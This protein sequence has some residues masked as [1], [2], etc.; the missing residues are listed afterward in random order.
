VCAECKALTQIKHE[1][2]NLH[3][4]DVLLPPDANAPRAL[5]VVPVHD[6]VDHQVQGD[7]DPGDRG[8]SDELCVAEE[9]R[10]AVVVGMEEG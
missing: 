5:E 2:D 10:C 9:G 4:G 1:L 6:N 7:R 8:V 3:D